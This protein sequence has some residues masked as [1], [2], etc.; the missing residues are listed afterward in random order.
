MV[1]RKILAGTRFCYR[2]TGLAGVVAKVSDEN[3]NQARG[4]ASLG[5]GDALSGTG[6][7]FRMVLS[8]RPNALPP[9]GAWPAVLFRCVEGVGK[10]SSTDRDRGLVGV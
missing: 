6:P 1:R 10:D 5:F 2:R 8:R 7:Q 3:E 9:S 4:A